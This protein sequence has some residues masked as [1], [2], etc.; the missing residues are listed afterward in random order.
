MTKKKMNK[1]HSTVIILLLLSLIVLL[2][3]NL[4]KPQLTKKAD[5]KINSST[6]QKTTSLEQKLDNIIIDEMCFEETKIETVLD[7]LRER[8][9]NLDPERTGINIVY[10]SGANNA[11][12]ETE[13]EDDF[14]AE[15]KDQ[16]VFVEEDAVVE[17]SFIGKTITMWFKD[18]SVKEA[19]HNICIAA[20]LQYTIDKHAVVITNKDHYGCGPYSKIF[21]VSADGMSII[22]D[23]STPTPKK[24]K[25]FFENMGVKFDDE[26]TRITYDKDISRLIATHYNDELKQIEEIIYKLN[27][28]PP[29]VLVTARFIKIPAKTLH[30]LK[31]EHRESKEQYSLWNKVILSDAC[32]IVA[33]ASVLTQNREETTM[34][35]VKEIYLP[36]SWSG[37]NMLSPSKNNVSPKGQSNF[38]KIVSSSSTPEFGESTEQ[39]LRFSVTPVIS[40][41]QST[42]K[43]NCIPVIQH[44]VGWTQY[45]NNIRM[46]VIKAFTRWSAAEVYD[47][48]TLMVA[49]SGEEVFDKATNSRERYYF[50]LLLSPRLIGADGI[51]LKKIHDDPNPITQ[52]TKK[53]A[54]K[55]IRLS[56]AEK[57]L[58]K[59]ILKSIKL[60]DYKIDKLMSKLSELGKKMVTPY[61]FKLV[62]DDKKIA[63]LPVVNLELNNIPWMDL[64][65]Y[66]CQQTNLR[67][68]I[69]D[70]QVLIGQGF[71]EKMTLRYFRLPPDFVNRIAPKEDID[72]ENSKANKMHTFISDQDVVLPKG[73]DVTFNPE[74]GRYVVDSTKTKF[75][76][77]A[78]SKSSILRDSLIKE[79]FQERGVQFPDGT[80][81]NY[82]TES[83]KLLVKNTPESL[84][85]M[86]KILGELCVEQVQ[87]CTESSIL[88]IK[89]KDL[90]KLLGKKVASSS[91]LSDS[92]INKILNSPKGKL[93]SSYKVISMSGE[94]GSARTVN[95]VYFPESWADADIGPDQGFV[96]TSPP[97][98]EFGES[99]DV[100]SRFILTATSSPDNSI[101]SMDLN[102]QV[103]EMIGWSKH[104]YSYS[105]TK[106]NTKTFNSQIK[107]PIIS[108]NDI[109]T[110]VKIP[111]G[112]TIL[113]GRAQ[114]LEY[115]NINKKSI[116]PNM[117]WV[118]F[119][120]KAKKDNNELKNIFFFIKANVAKPNQE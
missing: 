118:T 75:E 33:S 6:V 95:E 81:I 34:R 119:F 60:T 39:G 93:L 27:T 89:E 92:Q 88:E 86:D 45:N 29:Q 3:W 103:L 5:R 58:S 111:N 31:K 11:G 44:F 98:P 91:W 73:S 14:L 59:Q 66:I 107:M 23:N 109:T 104:D 64:I 116:N 79:Y 80:T 112:E 65:K 105:I 120:D 71:P 94:E 61:Q 13:S 22:T 74:T 19:I 9:Q 15:E 99:T 50:I 20:N 52:E 18:L 53:L 47:G 21:P 32:E 97:F 110:K 100:G 35:M 69:K 30:Q 57:M 67:Y 10:I 77:F 101:I 113:V 82:D 84:K 43:L 56:P 26:A 12:E 17:T 25:A 78:K 62:L 85:R 49:S 42:I 76:H 41:D 63:S 8:S 38:P 70:N 24:V 2:L 1:K 36:E 7:T 108:R 54:A 46:P 106:K 40:P 37:G 90:V 87:I 102:N 83:E 4:K 16:D 96:S 117:G 55:E 114:L 28:G 68:H 48:S 72:S 51:P 115:P